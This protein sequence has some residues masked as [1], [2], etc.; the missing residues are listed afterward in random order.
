[1]EKILDR[2]LGYV[3]VD[4]QSDENTELS[5]STLQQMFFAQSL[6]D[7]LR[8]IGL[9][10][11][12]VSDYGYVTATLPANDDT[13]RPTVGFIAHMDTSPDMSGKNVKPQIVT[14]YDGGEIVLNK[15]LNISMSPTDFPEMLHYIG[16]DLITTDGTTLLGADDKAG[17]AAIVTAMEYMLA[18][19]QIKHGK[20]RI[21]FTPDEEIGQGADH[22]DVAAFGADFAYTIDG[23]E[24]GE[25][26]FETFNAAAAVVKC[27]GRNVHPGAAYKKMRNS[28]RIAS[29]FINMIPRHDTPEHSR[30][31]EGF[32]HLTDMNGSV[33]LTELHYIIRDF[34]RDRFEMR[35]DE[36][37]HNVHRLNAEYGEGTIEIE[38]HD[39]YYNMREKIEPVMHIVELA[40]Q[41]M[42]DCNIEPKVLPVRGGTDGARLSFM[43][44]PTPNIFAGGL[45]FHGKYEFLPIESLKK[46]MNVIVRIAE[47]VK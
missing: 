24:V 36:M 37:L 45:N 4:T 41:A 16:Q 19:P 39:Q 44:L 2:F 8:K 40:K 25:L 26:E 33:E 22:F 47:L 1:M 32:Y 14:N 13:P 20:I 46:A 3:Q 5:P 10:D 6:A 11:V 43:G 34:N 12:S 21:A 30:D 28:M 31:Y 35:K 29:T 7:E 17:I 42:V 15:A 9:S 27:H 18:N 38:M 23:G